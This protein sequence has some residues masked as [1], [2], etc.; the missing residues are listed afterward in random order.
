MDDLQAAPEAPKAPDLP[1][2]SE[3]PS[4]GGQGT[5]EATVEVKDDDEA[6]EGE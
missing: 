2:T 4:E 6:P 5:D 1:E 3:G